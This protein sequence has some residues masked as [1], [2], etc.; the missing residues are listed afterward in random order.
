LASFLRPVLVGLL[1]PVPDSHR[2]PVSVTKGDLRM[3]EFD[4]QVTKVNHNYYS[5]YQVSV[6]YL[7]VLEVEVSGFRFLR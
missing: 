5:E 2:R 4:P 6:F 1:G 3:P 7:Q